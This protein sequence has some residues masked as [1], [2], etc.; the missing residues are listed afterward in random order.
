MKVRATVQHVIFCHWH[1]QLLCSYC[2]FLADDC[3]EY[4]LWHYYATV[5]EKHHYVIIAWADVSTTVIFSACFDSFVTMY[6]AVCTVKL[7]LFELRLYLKVYSIQSHLPEGIQYTK[8]LV[9]AV[10]RQYFEEHNLHIFHR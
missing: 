7:Y 6:N 4:S 9:S 8:P 5:R 3:F 1:S 10:C 2:M